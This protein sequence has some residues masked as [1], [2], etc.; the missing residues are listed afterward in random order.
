MNLS[1][2]LFKA[3]IFMLIG[4][5]LCK[6]FEPKPEA[7]KA[8]QAQVCKASIKKRTNPDGSIDEVTEFLAS[9]SQSSGEQV[10]KKKNGVGL[11][12]DELIY[13]RKVYELKNIDING[14]VK[15]TKDRADLGVMID[16]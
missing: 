14:L 1:L 15:I 5:Y 8:L 4:A 7:P 16:F 3:C 6:Q 2:E 9:Q 12:R 10:A 11:F 13:K